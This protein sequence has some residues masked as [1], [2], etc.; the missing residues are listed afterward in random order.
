VMSLDR[1]PCRRVKR[2]RLFAHHHTFILPSCVG[3][4]GEEAYCCLCRARLVDKL[5]MDLQEAVRGPKPRDSVAGYPRRLDFT[6]SP[7][8]C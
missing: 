6:Q 5:W 2:E 3:R 4:E 8:E 7:K 1:W